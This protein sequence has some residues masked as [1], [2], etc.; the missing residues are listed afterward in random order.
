M[1]KLQKGKVF[2]FLGIQGVALPQF[3]WLKSL[4]LISSSH[5]FTLFP[6]LEMFEVRFRKILSFFNFKFSCTHTTFHSF[7]GVLCVFGGKVVGVGGVMLLSLGFFK[8]M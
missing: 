4:F 6:K 8:N 7:W 3:L 2:L 1:S 5:Y